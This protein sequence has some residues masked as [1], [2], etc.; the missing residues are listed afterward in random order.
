MTI[1]VGI[2]CETGRS[3]NKFP[4]LDETL[5]RLLSFEKVELFSLND[6]TGPAPL[7][8]RSGL[9][10]G[11]CPF[12]AFNASLSL[13]TGEGERF[14]D[15]VSGARRLLV[16][17]EGVDSEAARLSIGEGKVPARGV[18]TSVP[19]SCPSGCFASG[20]DVDCNNGDDVVRN[21]M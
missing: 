11:L 1:V 3:G 8:F 6:V 9:V 10:F 12:R 18:N 21:P 4:S 17:S 7:A 2:G 15:P 5:P 19:S 16:S 14:W 20:R 13:P